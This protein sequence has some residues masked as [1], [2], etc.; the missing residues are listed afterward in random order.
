M[1]MQYI[2][3][4]YMNDIYV[5]KHTDPVSCRL[6]LSFPVR[7]LY[8]S[9]RLPIQAMDMPLLLAAHREHGLVHGDRGSN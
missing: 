4:Q 1:T 3:A 7:F 6:E 9:S 5:K 2:S 8:F